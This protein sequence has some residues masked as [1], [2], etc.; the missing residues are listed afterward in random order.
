[1]ENLLVGIEDS[2]GLT[3]AALPIQRGSKP[4]T[5]RFASSGEA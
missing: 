2:F 5:A 1:M 3:A 4:A